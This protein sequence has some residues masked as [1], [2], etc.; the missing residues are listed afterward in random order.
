MA[1][2]GEIARDAAMSAAEDHANRVHGDWSARAYL[3]VTKY[4]RRGGLFMAED[5]RAWAEGEGL[6]PPPDPR[7]WGAVIMRAAKEGLIKRIG[8]EPS[9]NRQA[10]LRPTAVWQV[11][12]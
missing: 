10:H 12:Q 4:I 11:C 5:V 6:P 7:A 1:S 3:M 8:Y 9:R 2:A